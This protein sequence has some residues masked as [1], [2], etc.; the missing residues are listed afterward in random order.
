MPSRS[1]FAKFANATLVFSIGKGK[2]IEDDNGNPI[3][4][5]KPFKVL[6]LLEP[7]ARETRETRGSDD[8][9][10]NFEGYLVNPLSL[11]DS[12]IPG[13]VATIELKE[14]KTRIIRG[15]FTLKP[16]TADPYVVGAG[17][18]LIN[19]IAGEMRTVV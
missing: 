7:K 4:Q 9:V 12:I 13:M 1:P 5:N 17:V 10:R 18:E 11:P 19:P 6:A 14:T 2:F 15:I 8:A 16:T 3:E